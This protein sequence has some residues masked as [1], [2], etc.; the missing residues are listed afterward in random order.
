MVT[1]IFYHE[2]KSI[3]MQP[4][5]SKPYK[6]ERKSLKTNYIIYK[7]IQNRAESEPN[8]PRKN[9]I[10][11]RNYSSEN[12]KTRTKKNRMPYLGSV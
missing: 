1:N 7:N 10:L 5:Q 12:R 8:E 2:P 9:P 4:N 3:L 11:V 6:Q